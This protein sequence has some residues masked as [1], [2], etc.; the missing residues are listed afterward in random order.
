MMMDFFE[1]SKFDEY[2]GKKKKKLKTEE[3]EILKELEVQSM[4]LKKIVKKIMHK[5][6]NSKSN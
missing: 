4:A 3:K 1:R 5:N 6:S 2:M